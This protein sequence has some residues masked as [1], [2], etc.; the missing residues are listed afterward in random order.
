MKKTL[1]WLLAWLLCLPA[2]AADP[3]FTVVTVDTSEQRL[4]L[5]LNDSV[6]RGWRGLDRLA[7]ALQAR[8]QRLVFAMNAGMYHP[9][10]APVGLF[11]Q[12]GK[13][14][15]PL[16]LD[17]GKGNF[18]LKPNG[19]FFVGEA[20]PRVVAATEYAAL[21]KGV[22]LASQSGPLLLRDGLIHPAFNAQSTSRLIR[23]GV[24]VLGNKAYFVISEAP[25]NFYEFAQFFRDQLHC[26]DALYFDGT[27]SSLYWPAQHRNDA[28][29]ALGP[30]I[31]VVE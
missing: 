3:R 7:E 12:D 14:I 2:R 13:Q 17:D 22:R 29:A 30:I 19:V 23:N 27:V 16:N 8:G 9:D 15:T 6:G 4:E 1:P 26:R 21:A 10:F 20:G 5:F 25:V 28:A 24:G 31:G 18:F 11:V